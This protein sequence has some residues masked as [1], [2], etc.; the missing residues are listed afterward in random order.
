MAGERL[1]MLSSE[2]IER[3]DRQIRV[4]GVRAQEKL[5]AAKVVIVGAGG[6]GSPV[7]YYLAAAGVGAIAIVDSENVELSNLNRQIL[8]WTIDVG[9][10][11]VVSAKEKLERLNP[12][13]RV[14]AV[15]RKIG[16]VEDAVEIIRDADV[17]IDCLDNW[18]TRFALNEACVRL[19]KPLV[20]AGVR[21][22]YGQVT[23]IKPFEGP[24]L[25]CIFPRNP[26]E[27]ASFPIAG[28]LPGILGAL[29]S[30]EAL[31]IISGY[32]ET[33]TGKLLFYDGYRNTFDIVKVER[34]PDCPVCGSKPQNA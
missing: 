34:R 29:E 5:K 11:K 25:R 3:Y 26:P 10:P 30:L 31:K 14:Q 24:C 23:V 4:W 9:K 32:G 21:A 6:L 7:A 19:R 8:H 18:A 12:H 13:V 16:K 22:L 28:P 27:E 2:E 1:A 17:V 33:L 15:N 20:H